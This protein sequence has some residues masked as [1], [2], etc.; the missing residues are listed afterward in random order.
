MWT[1]S[2]WPILMRP[3]RVIRK[4][5]AS[6]MIPLCQL[7]TL[8]H[9]GSACAYR[10]ARPSSSTSLTKKTARSKKS[11]S[12]S[13]LALGSALSS[14]P[15]SS[16]ADA[17]LGSAAS[18]SGPQRPVSSLTLAP[19]QCFTKAVR[20][21][22]GCCGWL[23]ETSFHRPLEPQEES[24]HPSKVEITSSDT[25]PCTGRHLLRCV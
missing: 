4:L 22:G 6:R 2:K 20:A 9:T 15:G 25:F 17:H 3:P 11:A 12:P 5:T 10:L 24:K 8:L 18:I 1:I 21:L 19:E 16:R 23:T 13:L 7:I 14:V